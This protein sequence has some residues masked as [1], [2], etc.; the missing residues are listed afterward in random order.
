MKRTVSFLLDNHRFSLTFASTIIYTN[1]GTEYDAACT[2]QE[3]R[4]YFQQLSGHLY[5]ACYDEA[6]TQAKVEADAI[7][8]SRRGDLEDPDNQ[9]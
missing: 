3:L 8:A 7:L 4:D 5:A 2:P 6:Q 9:I 1:G